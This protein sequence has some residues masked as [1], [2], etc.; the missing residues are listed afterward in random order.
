MAVIDDSISQAACNP[1]ISYMFLVLT[2]L[3]V[4]VTTL[5]NAFIFM[6]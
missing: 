1:N 5:S 3:V 4:L 6:N 2:A